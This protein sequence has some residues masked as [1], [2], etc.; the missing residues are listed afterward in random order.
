LTA[1]HEEQLVVEG[2]RG[3]E[4]TMTWSSVDLTDRSEWRKAIP[5]RPKAR[6]SMPH[7]IAANLDRGSFDL[8]STTGFVIDSDFK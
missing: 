8:F 6:P 5:L 1:G 4:E 2:L 3:T 7:T